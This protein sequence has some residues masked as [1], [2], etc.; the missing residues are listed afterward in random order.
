MLSRTFATALP[1]A[2]LLVASPASAEAPQP[3]PSDAGRPYIGVSA[4]LRA[5]QQ[6]SPLRPIAAEIGGRV[7]E[8]VEAGVHAEYASSASESDVFTGRGGG[9]IRYHFRRNPIVDPWI[10]GTV[11]LE[12]LSPGKHTAVPGRSAIV[13]LV[14]P[15]PQIGL[16]L[17]MWSTQVGVF[18]AVD[19]VP[20][21]ITVDGLPPPM[22]SV[23]SPMTATVG[24]RVAQML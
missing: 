2:L 7:A 14:F 21:R 1:L 11:G 18:A 23:S 15:S 16:D 3:A 10:G 4:G 12:V 24:V 17:R 5:F 22:W 8:V 20:F 6:A 19:Y 13:G 9:I